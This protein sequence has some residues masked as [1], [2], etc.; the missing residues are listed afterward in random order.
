[1]SSLSVHKVMMGPLVPR[2]M[3]L[4]CDRPRNHTV[5]C[6]AKIA[7]V[8]EDAE[9][10]NKIGHILRVNGSFRVSDTA[11]TFKIEYEIFY[12]EQDQEKLTPLQ[13]YRK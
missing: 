1:M 12:E 13:V 6:S 8:T 9:F 11:S 7:K 3:D 4:P 10:D 5:L 2:T